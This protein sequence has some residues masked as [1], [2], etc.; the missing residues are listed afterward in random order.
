MKV[1]Y[2]DDRLKFSIEASDENKLDDIVK[3]IAA[4]GSN[5]SYISKENVEKFMESLDL[6][7]SSTELTYKEHI[8]PEIL[9]KDRPVV[10]KRLP[11][12]IDLNDFDVQKAVTEEPG[13][14]CPNCYQSS[15]LIVKT[16]VNSYYMRRTD[17]SGYEVVCEFSNEEEISG[18]RF[19]GFETA[20]ITDYKSDIYKIKVSK[21]FKDK[22][23]GININTEIMCPICGAIKKANEWMKCNKNP[24]EYGCYYDNPCIICGG[25]TVE[26]ILKNKQI[27]RTCEDCGHQITVKGGKE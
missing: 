20:S 18:M 11:N 26:K 8:N 27:K 2:S 21:S 7:K 10:R 22:D 23:I 13:M 17:A 5:K 19:K 3:L 12:E 9:N 15:F 6:D 16:G 14:T 24:S 25:E 4:F 1:S